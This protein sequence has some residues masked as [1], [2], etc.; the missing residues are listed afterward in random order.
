MR[1][2]TRRLLR[3][4]RSPLVSLL[5]A[6]ALS[7]AV[8]RAQD[9]TIGGPAEVTNASPFT[10][11]H[12]QLPNRYQ[13][14]YTASSFT[15]PVFIDAVRLSNSLSVAAGLPASI[16]AGE[17]LVRFAVTDRPE[18]GLGTDFAANV[19]GFASTF[20]AGVF[21]AGGLRL[22]GTPYLYDPARG[23]LLL[24]VTVLAQADVG[25]LGFDYARSAADGTSRVS[26]YFPPP[27]TPPFPVVADAGGLVTTFETRPAVAAVPEPTSVLLVA[28]GLAGLGTL[29]RRRRFP[30]PVVSP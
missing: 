11:Y 24:D 13:Q 27:F 17:Y 6:T 30:R 22:A 5:T 9:V 4:L 21:S 12:F 16:A 7:A 2:T 20:F 8:A 29:R 15:G 1:C 18:N 25:S 3:P 19:T 10:N 26:H 28:G 23:N 14:L